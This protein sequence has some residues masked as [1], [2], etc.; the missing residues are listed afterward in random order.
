[1]D[2]AA[3]LL[4]VEHLSV[5]FLKNRVWRSAVNGVSFAVQRGEIMGLVGESG[6]GKSLTGQAIMGLVGKKKHESVKGRVLFDDVDLVPKSEK[7]MRAFRGNRI[8]LIA[9]D[10]TTSLNP[11]F[12]V[13]SQ[14]AEVPMLHH[15]ASRKGAWGIA[16][17]MLKRVG[18]S[19]A[20]ERARQFPHQFSGGMRQRGVIAMGLAGKPDLLIADEPTT[21][22]DVTIQAQILDLLR[23]L[24]DRTG[25]G[26][27][28][29]THDLGVVAELCDSVT[30]MYAG[31]VVE[32]AAVNALFA[33]PTHPYTSS[34]LA[35]VP[36][37]E[38]GE[39]LEPIPGQPPDLEQLR[40][41]GCPFFDRCPLA[42]DV[43]AA[44]MPP[45]KG[46]ADHRAACWHRE[47]PQ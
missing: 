15:S 35:S 16:V 28:F 8:A 2:K 4:K 20:A 18:L 34:L 3:P 9:Q 11:V 39:R 42:T 38:S 23:D 31:Q 45:L 40:P 25:C 30:V 29:I 46:R 5:S 41:E 6:C 17:D 37:L 27:L 14:I 13:G 32:T 21:A 43:C 10:P 47:V 33:H 36:T 44:S 26:I 24:R 1:M 7:Q 12:T 22:L 19:D